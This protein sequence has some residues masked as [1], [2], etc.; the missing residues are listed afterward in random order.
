VNILAAKVNINL[1]LKQKI[2]RKKE[3]KRRKRGCH[4]VISLVTTVFIKLFILK[5]TSWDN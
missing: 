4:I 5:D 2:K 1:G 3:R